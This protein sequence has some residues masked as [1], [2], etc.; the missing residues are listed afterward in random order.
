[1]GGVGDVVVGGLGVDG[2]AEEVEGVVAAA[3]GGLVGGGFD[4]VGVGAR[5]DAVERRQVQDRAGRELAEFVGGAVGVGMT[6]EFTAQQQWDRTGDV[7]GRF[8]PVLSGDRR[9]AAR[10]LLR[11][12]IGRRVVDR[13][14][15]RTC[16]Q[17]GRS[18]RPVVPTSCGSE[19]EVHI[20]SRCNCIC[21]DALKAFGKQL[22]VGVKVI[23]F[24]KSLQR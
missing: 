14:R 10:C 21:D 22:Y 20:T 12:G 23:Q 17:A 19:D 24:P 18:P 8:G 6:A 4:E 9:R 15:C 11:V 13:M 1:M 3:G 7:V 2:V 16:G 5:D